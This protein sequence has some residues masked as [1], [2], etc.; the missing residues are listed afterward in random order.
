MN[1]A[2]ISRRSLGINF[3]SDAP[4][5]IL[6]WAPLAR[7]LSAIINS[8][9]EVA[10]QKMHYGYWQAS[11]PGLKPGD[12]YMLQINGKESFPDPASLHQPEGVH[13]ASGVI[14]LREIK[15]IHYENWKGIDKKDL[16][17]YE[18]HV[19]TF[20]SEGTFSGVVNKLN[21]LKQ[22]GI[23]AIKIM[24][25]SAYPGNRN[26]GYDGVF[27][28]ATQNSYG[29]P[30]EF[31]KL[32]KACHEKGL[33][34]ILDVVYN[35][36]GPEGNYLNAFG[37]YFTDKYKTP[38]G[39]AINFDDEWCDGVRHYFIENALMWLRDFRIDGLRLDAVHAIKDFS[40]RHFLKELSEHLQKLN[41]ETGTNHF[42]IGECDLNDTRFINP[43]NKDGYGLDSQW[44]DEWHHA[45]H[46]LV[47]GESNG[48]YSDFGKLY[49]LTK[50]FNH[51]YVYNGNYSGYRKKLFGTSTIGQPG[52]KFVIFTQNHDQVGNRM[53]GERLSNL[54]DFEALKLAA[55]AMF[56]SPFIP[57]IFMGEE[58][59]GDTPFLYFI[60]HGDEHLVE[61]V[62][63]GRKREFR[64]FMKNASPP[65]PFAVET[66]E[67]S[68]LKWD[69]RD[70]KQ[71][72]QMLAFYKKC[73]QLKKEYSLLKPGDRDNANAQEIIKDRVMLYTR[74]N[75]EKK[76]A[77][78]LNFSE[79]SLRIET[80]ELSQTQTELLLY[81]SH[82]KW[83]GNIPDKENPLSYS[84]DNATIRI[85]KKSMVLFII[86][87]K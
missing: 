48:Y 72:G 44:C 42:L 37:P 77:A 56:I 14:D 54:V 86:E 67:K 87:K 27:P 55:G 21:Y 30:L 60:S 47:T 79:Q 15:N 58:Y 32:I 29:G 52:E 17:I 36:L 49:H 85:E 63:K 78:F 45:L 59:A 8:K 6:V 74:Y 31:A 1:S 12:R 64:D 81:T 41:R 71:K 80:D 40:P 25:V 51:G 65:D 5:T 82:K 46:A 13:K 57:M 16:I 73:I 7:K 66:F 23:N 19:G 24:P 22:L 68:K 26:W 10:L 34:V 20:T 53:L 38:W 4:P 2:L 18:L 50:S 62:R 43:L 39:K 11:L 3:H 76:I 70:D 9:A 61:Q 84:Q 75:A 35:H 33:A 83:G 69:F 28:F